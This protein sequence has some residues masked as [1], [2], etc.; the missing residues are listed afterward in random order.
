ML[1]TAPTDFC[2]QLS[3]LMKFQPRKTGTKLFVPG[4][5]PDKAWLL[6]RGVV[7]CWTPQANVVLQAPH[8]V[9]ATAI[10]SQKDRY[11][12]AEVESDEAVL[13]CLPSSS[14]DEFVK[15][16]PMLLHSIRASERRIASLLNG[17]VLP[18]LSEAAGAESLQQQQKMVSCS[19]ESQ[20]APNGL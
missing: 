14:F 11:F 20:M 9:G 1:A 17:D 4:D 8:W 3:D 7:K 15:L 5:K 18:A 6:V 10:F 19:P 2:R 16:V 13:L 12:V